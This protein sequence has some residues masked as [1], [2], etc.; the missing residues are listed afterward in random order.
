MAV[1]ACAEMA[2]VVEA[3]CM[4]NVRS[5]CSDAGAISASCFS[6]EDLKLAIAFHMLLGNGSDHDSTQYCSI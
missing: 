2:V 4:S 1:S 6:N 3:Y 5:D